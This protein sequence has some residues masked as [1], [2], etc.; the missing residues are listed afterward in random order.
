VS[1]ALTNKYADAEVL[2]VDDEPDICFLLSNFI[3]QNNYTTC[4]VHDLA[5]AREALLHGR[6]SLVFLDNRLGDGRGVNFIKHIKSV[7]PGV[8]VIMISA[9]DNP[10]DKQE[11]FNNGAD[12]FISK[13]LRYERILPAIHKLQLSKTSKVGE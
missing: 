6:F 13:P 11:A 1:I 5:H 10:A 9:Y 8:V 3:K 2:I 7:N 12:E 4:C